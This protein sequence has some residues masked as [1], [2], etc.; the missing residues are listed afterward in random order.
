[1][2]ECDAPCIAL[3]LGSSGSDI[4][5]KSLMAWAGVRTYEALGCTSL[6]TA[7]QAIGLNW[8]DA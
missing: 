4:Q 3:W 2:F 7:A 6:D 1:M 5:P 8:H